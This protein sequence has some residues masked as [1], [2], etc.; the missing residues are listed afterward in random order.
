MNEDLGEVAYAAYCARTGWKSL[1]SGAS[2]PSWQDVPSEI[3]SA[4]RAAAA[5]VR[6]AIEAAP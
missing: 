2:L 3:R 4:W 1:I 6:A 5:A